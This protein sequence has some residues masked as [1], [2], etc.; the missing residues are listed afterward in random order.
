MNSN[1]KVIILLLLIVSSA[2][3]GYVYHEL[4]ND[5]IIQNA[6]N[7]ICEQRFNYSKV[8]FTIIRNDISGR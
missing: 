8:N 7:A 5:I 3:A 4:E 6:A 1:I 2:Y